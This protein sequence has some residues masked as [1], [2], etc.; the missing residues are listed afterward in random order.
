MGRNPLAKLEQSYGIPDAFRLIFEDVK[1]QINLGEIKEA[2]QNPSN[3]TSGSNTKDT[4]E[5]AGPT[6]FMAYYQNKMLDTDIKP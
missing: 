2:D 6:S 4:D 1:K 3:D 5:Q